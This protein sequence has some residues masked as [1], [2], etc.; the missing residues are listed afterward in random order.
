MG[1]VL[2]TQRLVRLAARSDASGNLLLNSVLQLVE[3]HPALLRAK[4]A[5]LKGTVWHWA[6]SRGHVVL[7]EGLIRLVIR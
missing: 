2:L 6:A 1:N 3:Q 7:L 4:C 5:A